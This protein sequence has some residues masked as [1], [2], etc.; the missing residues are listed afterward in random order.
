ML[1]LFERVYVAQASQELLV[2]LRAVVI[3]LSM[4]TGMGHYTQLR[5]TPIYALKA[6]RHEYHTKANATKSVPG[7]K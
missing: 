1:L 5:S 7:L 6:G 4:V 2:L 3:G